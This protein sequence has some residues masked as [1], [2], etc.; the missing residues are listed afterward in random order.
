MSRP[1]RR[2]PDS[3]SPNQ[4]PPSRAKAWCQLRS[5]IPGGKS[6]P[7][8]SVGVPLRFADNQNHI[9]TGY[10]PKPAIKSWV[11]RRSGRRCK[12]VANHGDNS[13]FSDSNGYSCIEGAIGDDE[14]SSGTALMA[15]QVAWL[16]ALQNGGGVT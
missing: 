7:A 4:G 10:S 15:A 16:G 1:S 8:P 12:D 13:D 11:I 6:L 5:A 9:P 3:F 14:R 2:V